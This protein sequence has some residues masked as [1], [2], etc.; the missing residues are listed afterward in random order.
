MD[1]FDLLPKCLISDVL[2]SNFCPLM[3]TVFNSL[4]R[5]FMFIGLVYCTATK[6]PPLK[7]ILNFGPLL[8][9][10]ENIPA[11]NKA[12]D[13]RIVNLELL[14]KSIFDSFII[15]KINQRP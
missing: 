12:P 11:S 3:V 2:K 10:R 5:L 9:I 6:V 15:Y 8:I 4:R 7:S 14:I 13:K 1:T